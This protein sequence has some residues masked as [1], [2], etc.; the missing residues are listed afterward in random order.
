M[1][2]SLD[3]GEADHLIVSSP[4]HELIGDVKHRALCLP[5][6][7]GPAVERAVGVVVDGARQLGLASPGLPVCPLPLAW[8]F[9][10]VPSLSVGEL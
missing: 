10:A 9:V 2:S 3:V 1:T 6:R 5:G 8:G 4:D 7:P